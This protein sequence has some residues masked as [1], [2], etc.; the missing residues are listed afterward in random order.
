[1]KYRKFGVHL[2]DVKRVLARSNFRRLKIDCSGG[3]DTM[4][5]KMSYEFLVQ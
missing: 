4:N 2:L 1:V 5:R 3:I